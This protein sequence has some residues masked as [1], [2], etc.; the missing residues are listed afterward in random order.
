MNINSLPSLLEMDEQGGSR[1]T[2]HG[3]IWE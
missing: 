2:T 3:S 1:S